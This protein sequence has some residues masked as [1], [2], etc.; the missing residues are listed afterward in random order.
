[1]FFH[2]NQTSE[3]KK[4]YYKNGFAVIKDI[5]PKEDIHKV[6]KK[7]LSKLNKKNKDYY[8][9]KF[10]KKNLLRRIER[11]TNYFS[12]IQNIAYSKKIFKILNVS[13][14]NNVLFKDKLNFKFPNGAG[15]LPHIDG[16]FFWSKKDEKKIQK[17]W[18][19][20]SNKFT[21][22]AIH[23]D[24]ATKKNGCLFIANKNDT[25][26][27][28]KNW[29]QITNKLAFNTPNISKKDFNKFKF[30]PMEVDIGDVVIFDWKCAHYSTKNKSKNSRMILYF[31]YCQNKSKKIRN[32]YYLDKKNSQTDEKFKGCIY[33]K[34]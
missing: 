8:F 18:K 17:G 28:G 24:K 30:H 13:Y 2:Q 16:H 22:I 27:I 6:K 25:K 15:F 20:Y 10:G 21:N 11:V 29:G 7:V 12:D 4:F 32:K 14:K 26:K 3:I 23:L 33:T 9:E 34:N 19:V 31:T 5:F 1:M